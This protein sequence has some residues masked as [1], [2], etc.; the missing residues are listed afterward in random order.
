MTCVLA[1]L[2]GHCHNLEEAAV[3][4]IRESH[5]DHD[6]GTNA[7][8][9]IDP[10]FLITHTVSLQNGPEMYKTFRDKKPHGYRL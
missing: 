7:M 3:V 10:S 6:A 4:V 1:P 8:K 5:F 2:Q 9:E